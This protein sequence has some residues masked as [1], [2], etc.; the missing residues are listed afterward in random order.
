MNMGKNHIRIC[1]HEQVRL[2]MLILNQ[3]R[4]SN[5]DPE[6]VHF[7]SKKLNGRRFPPKPLQKLLVTLTTI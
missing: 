4:V 2:D 3:Y 6:K 7:L 1:L 5:F